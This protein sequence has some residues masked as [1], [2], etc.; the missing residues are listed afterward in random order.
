MDIVVVVAVIHIKTEVNKHHHFFFGILIYT[1]LILLLTTSWFIE[2]EPIRS[3]RSLEFRI[4]FSFYLFALAFSN[5]IDIVVSFV[6]NI[7]LKM[8]NLSNLQSSQGS[9]LLWQQK[10]IV[11]KN[12]QSK[13]YL[14]IHEFIELYKI[15]YYKIFNLLIIY[16]SNFSFIFGNF[17]YIKKEILYKK[18]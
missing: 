17:C 11:K 2:L 16:E 3:G 5:L 14:S 10:K 13:K 8:N 18:I 9:L 4:F 15:L 1:F 7:L 12:A 6:D